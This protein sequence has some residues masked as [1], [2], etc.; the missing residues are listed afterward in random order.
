MIDLKKMSKAL[1]PL[2]LMTMGVAFAESEIADSSYSNCC[3]TNCCKPCCVPQPKKCIDCECYNP[4]YYDLQCDWGV[5]VTGDFLYWYARETN[6]DYAVSSRIFVQP[7][8]VVT[9]APATPAAVRTLTFPTDH[10]YIKSKWDPAFR[11]GLGWNMCSGWDTYLNWTYFR[12]HASNSRSSTVATPTAQTRAGALSL[13]GQE[14]LFNPWAALINQSAIGGISAFLPIGATDISG[15][16]HL[17]FNQIDLELGFRYWVT[18][19]FNIRPYVGVRGAWTKTHFEVESIF[20]NP[21]LTTIPGFTVGPT[22]IAAENTF[23]NKY[24]GVGLIGGIQPEFMLGDWCGCGNF[25]IYGNVDGAALWGKF[26]GHNSYELASTI[27]NTTIVTV[28]PATVTNFINLAN[29]NGNDHFNRMQG[30]LDVGLGLRWEEHWCCDRYSTSIDLGWEHHY[31]FD[32][33]MYHRTYG[34][35]EVDL[36]AAPLNLVADT[37]QHTDNFMTNLGFGGFVLRLRFDF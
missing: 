33:G 27:S 34:G 5:Y 13:D 21:S 31:W 10:H 35:A 16:W 28:G 4:Q 32:F 8:T 14:A 36:T 20:N 30:I 29:P 23:N 9:P 24:W 11:I 19:C 37:F 2:S 26:K 18:R 25:S 7:A 17:K 1:I 15:K 6:L 3:P 12:S 22:F